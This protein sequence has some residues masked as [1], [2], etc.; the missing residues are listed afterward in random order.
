MSDKT[1]T[2]EATAEAIEVCR[3]TR[4]SHAFQE[5]V[6]RRLDAFAEAAVAA[7]RA[8][9]LDKLVSDETVEA[10]YR[11]ENTLHESVRLD[12]HSRSRARAALAAARHLLAEPAPT[13][14]PT[15]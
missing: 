11:A 6:A 5:S 10:V 4:C 3:L 15:T 9:L 13:K 8:R 1:P 12:P 7:E 14:G 2:A